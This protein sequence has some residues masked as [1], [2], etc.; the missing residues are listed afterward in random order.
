M[1]RVVIFKPLYF[2]QTFEIYPKDSNK[3]IKVAKLLFHSFT[4]TF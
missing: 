1:V 4:N 3:S 2:M